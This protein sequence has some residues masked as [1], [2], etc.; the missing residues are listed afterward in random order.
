MDFDNASGKK[1]IF[2]IH[3]DGKYWAESV[4][5]ENK[6]YDY[7]SALPSPFAH[8]LDELGDEAAVDVLFSALS[9]IRMSG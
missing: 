2:R 4:D 1:A 3:G 8:G 6:N 7:L 5:G 9:V